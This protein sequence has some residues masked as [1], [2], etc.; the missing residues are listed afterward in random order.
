MGALRRLKQRDGR[1]K[2]DG[3]YRVTVAK[4]ESANLGHGQVVGVRWGLVK[5]SIWA[6]LSSLPGSSVAGGGGWIMEAI[7]SGY[8]QELFE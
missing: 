3:D 7:S 4:T 1:Q 2:T 8:L 5:F 6:L